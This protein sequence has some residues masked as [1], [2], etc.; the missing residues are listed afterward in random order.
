MSKNSDNEYSEYYSVWD[1]S[2]ETQQEIKDFYKQMK[3][4]EGWDD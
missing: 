4:D 3:E 2:P 1:D